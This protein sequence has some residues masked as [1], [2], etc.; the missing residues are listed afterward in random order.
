MC[1]TP[2]LAA[3]NLP[4]E[5][6]ASVVLWVSMNMGQNWMRYEADYF[7]KYYGA[8]RISP[9]FGPQQDQNTVVSFYGFNLFQ[10]E[11]RKDLF[12]GFE[13]Q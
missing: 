10:G 8:K 4:P 11:N 3:L 6:A 7:F 1:R 5:T 12:P 9:S 13:Y 2:A